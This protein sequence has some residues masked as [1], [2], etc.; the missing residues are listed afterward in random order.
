MTDVFYFIRPHTATMFIPLLFVAILIGIIM[1]PI[2][3]SK[4]ILLCAGA[5][6]LFGILA[7]FSVSTYESFHLTTTKIHIFSE[8]SNY[9]YFKQHIKNI[10][11]AIVLALVVYKLPLKLFT[12]HRTIKWIVIAA[13]L[14]Q[15]AVFI[16]LIGIKLHGAR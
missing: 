4:K 13:V 9:Y 8:P 1:L 12:Q 10:V 16:P 5:L 14:L 6:T 2:A 11:I 7:V 15:I 3:K